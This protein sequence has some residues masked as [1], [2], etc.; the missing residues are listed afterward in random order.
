M[1][2]ICVLSVF[3]LFTLLAGVCAVEADIAQT[4]RNLFWDT[5]IENVDSFPSYAPSPE[6]SPVPSRKLVS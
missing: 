4:E 3:A 5:Y 1:M 6:P 2:K